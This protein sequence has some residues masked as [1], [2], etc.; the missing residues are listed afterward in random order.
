MQKTVFSQP[1]GNPDLIALLERHLADA[2]AGR[3]IAIGIV[4]IT[5]QGILN[6]QST[7]DTIPLAVGAAQLQRQLLDAIFPPA[8]QA[9]A[10]ATGRLSS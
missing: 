5:S 9:G 4:S 3:T 7:G 10:L 2:R 1:S 8:K 6:L